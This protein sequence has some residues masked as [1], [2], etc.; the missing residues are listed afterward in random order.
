VCPSVAVVSGRYHYTNE[1]K[2]DG[3]GLVQSHSQFSLKNDPPTH[4]HFLENYFA[5][6][7]I[8]NDQNNF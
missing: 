3:V 5:E 6:V 1:I 8:K 7:K 4:T 2:C